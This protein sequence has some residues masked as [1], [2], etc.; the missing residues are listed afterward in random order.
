MVSYRPLQERTE[1]FGI[2]LE[3]LQENRQLH[4][5]NFECSL[6]TVVV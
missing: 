6:R 3:A 2:I 4:L 5:R 1:R